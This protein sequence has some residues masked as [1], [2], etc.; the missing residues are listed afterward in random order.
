MIIGNY[1]VR[2]Y[3]RRIEGEWYIDFAVK[4]RE[5]KVSNSKREPRIFCQPDLMVWPDGPEVLPSETFPKS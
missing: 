2:E 4:S 3:G 1:I 5:N